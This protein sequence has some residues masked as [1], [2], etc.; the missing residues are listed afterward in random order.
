M[1]PFK[2]FVAPAAALLVAAAAPAA[3][4]AA[5]SAQRVRAD[6]EFLA[7]DLLEGRAPGTRGH[8]IAAAYVVAQFQ[9]L[10]LKPGGSDGS[11]YQD[12]PLRRADHAEPPQVGS[13]RDGKRTEL[14]MGSDAGA[15]PSLV[16]RSID[17][18]SEL[19]FA[20]HGL[21]DVRLGIDEYAGIDPRGKIVVVL[22][23]SP[24]NIAPEVAMH[25]QSQKDEIAARK[26]AAGLIEVGRTDD[27][28]RKNS[29]PA[30]FSSRPVTD[31][32][33]AEARPR[34]DLLPVELSVSA[35]WAERLFAGAPR[36]LK[37]I[38]ADAAA[39]RPLSAFTL[40]GRL[41]V[42]T[43]SSWSDFSSPQ[44]VAVL[45]GTDAA[46]ND[47]YVLLMGHI[48][49]LGVVP[50]AKAGE[51]AIYNGALD[52]AAGVATLIEAARRF[53]ATG[54]PRRSVMFL[55]TTAEEQGLLGAKYFAAEPPVPLE[56]IVGLVNLDMPLLLYDF[57]DVV[58]F[59]ATRSSL[60]PTIGAA[61]ADMGVSL[62][63]DPMP[64]EA[65]FV[66]SDH[67]PLVLKGV[68]GVF[69]MTGHANG[70]KAAWEKFLPH[71][72]H[73]PHDDML[74]EI[75]WQA[76]AKFAELNYRI[77]RALADADRRP[78]W[79]RHDYFG[80]S[81]AAGRAKAEKPPSP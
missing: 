38:R 17:L 7:S 1:N 81:F 11:W 21:S 3:Q 44:V 39:G 72:Y 70:G 52:N 26:G 74:Q 51:D 19:V 56:R 41:A 23:G 9:S 65:L 60:G 62:A 32:I 64:G 34:D 55:A 16:N 25:L 31:W 78:M 77:A 33:A 45:P 43:R 14:A 13:V 29:R 28:A 67:Y 42:R 66:R 47:E 50:D 73:K 36:S 35:E 37:A 48:D 30:L 6:V 63:E 5:D 79:Y 58:A 4:P 59:G 40:P 27:A 12:V 49:H 10:G 71:T 69:L 46:L 8:D 2:L 57:T 54:A 24:A 53:T 20:G 15:R 22:S 61:A 68:P 18:E 75:D 76:A 80:E